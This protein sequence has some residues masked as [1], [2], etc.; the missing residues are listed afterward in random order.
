[1]QWS[2]RWTSSLVAWSLAQTPSILGPR[3]EWP[4]PPPPL[5]RPPTNRR[6]C[7][8]TRREGRSPRRPATSTRTPL[9]RA[10]RGPCPAPWAPSQVP[11][12]G[13]GQAR[14]SAEPAVPST[15][16]TPW[17]AP[18]PLS[19]WAPPCC[20][21]A[22]PPASQP[23]A[24]RGPPRRWASSLVKAPPAW[25]DPPLQPLRPRPRRSPGRR[26]AE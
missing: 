24:P 5:P 10:T 14:G 4:L 9:G 1:M 25:G 12:R 22:D 19:P 6:R 2:H 15:A 23:W 13:W 18:P 16:R 11:S 3:T 21:A 8:R 20:P 26:W 17:A 7:N